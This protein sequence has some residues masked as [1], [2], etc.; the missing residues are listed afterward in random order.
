MPLRLAR[1]PS[2]GPRDVGREWWVTESSLWETMWKKETPEG[3]L[4]SSLESKSEV[5]HSC[6][7]LC[8]PMD[9]RPP[10]SSVHGIF[11]GKNSRVGSHFLLQG[12]FLPQGLNS[13][14]QHCRQTLYPL[15]HQGIPIFST[16]HPATRD[17]LFKQWCG[18]FHCLIES[19]STAFRMHTGLVPATSPVSVSPFP[20]PPSSSQA[21][22]SSDLP[23]VVLALGL[24]TCWFLCPLLSSGSLHG[25]RH[26]SALHSWVCLWDAFL[27]VFHSPPLSPDPPCLSP[28][29]IC[30]I[31]I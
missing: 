1:R 10:G 29:P 13:G 12:I 7:T 4:P 5:A 14:L 23:S 25:W 27:T 20:R 22:W 2:S 9:C 3:M 19:L 18:S 21:F 24:D 15:S 30:F 28:D 17:E 8:N 31:V 26:L 16:F 6:L 11:P